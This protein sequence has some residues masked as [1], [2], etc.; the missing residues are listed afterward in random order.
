MH[1]MNTEFLDGLW[2]AA[3]PIVDLSTG[4]IVGYE[5]L[6]RGKP[7]SAWT[8]PAQLFTEARRQGLDA[9]LEARCRTLGINWALEHLT[10]TQKLFLNIN[11]KYASLPIHGHE[12]SLTTTRIALEI[13]EDHNTLENADCLQQIQQWREDGYNIV[14]D[15]YG[16][17]YAGLGLLLAIQPHIVKID[18]SLITGIDHHIVRQSVVMHFR[19]LAVDQGI[20]L[21]AEGIETAAELHILQQMGIPLGQGFALGRPQAEPAASPVP[22]P[23]KVSVGVS[24]ITSPASDQEI[25]Q[26]AA[27]MA[28]DTSFPTYIVTRTR[29]IVAWNTAAVTLTGWS[30]SQI[31]QHPCHDR[32]LNHHDLTGR[33]LCVGACPL[34]WTMAKNRAHKQRLIGFSAEGKPHEIEVLATPLWNPVTHK[35]VG[36]IEYFWP[37][38]EAELF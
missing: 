19:D 24:Q 36:A 2:V 32:R 34:V 6:I 26:K 5:T 17:G 11:G 4:D 30:Q 37:V 14:I 23:T 12:P 27:E 9:T 20:T 10:G 3:Q 38:N 22:L 35:I 29:R 25:L 31:E 1:I 33:P 28:Y 15:D 8:S 7:G 16:V 18:R 21:L 13:S